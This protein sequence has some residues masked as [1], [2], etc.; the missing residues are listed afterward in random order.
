MPA[1]LSHG[2]RFLHKLTHASASAC[3]VEE[4]IQ[5]LR[6]EWRAVWT[7]MEHVWGGPLPEGMQR[8][9]QAWWLLE[10]AMLQFLDRRG[11]DDTDVARQKCVGYIMYVRDAKMQDGTALFAQGFMTYSVHCL[12]HLGTQYDNWGR[13]TESWNFVNERYAGI[14]TAMVVHWC[15]K[16]SLG[17]YL[18]PRVSMRMAALRS[19]LEAAPMAHVEV[20]GRPVEGQ[21]WADLSSGDL[22]LHTTP[23]SATK[24]CG[25][26][27]DGYSFFS[28]C[29]VVLRAPTGRT[30]RHA[31]KT[32][33]ATYLQDGC[34]LTV[35]SVR[36]PGEFVSKWLVVD[37]LHQLQ[38]ACTGCRCEQDQ[39]GEWCV[40]GVLLETS[41]AGRYLP[42]LQ[43]PQGWVETVALP[44]P[45][46]QRLLAVVVVI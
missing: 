1:A 45:C 43:V 7:D 2:R 39:E 28:I 22:H 38:K 33:F 40:V 32:P 9:G 31:T 15:H 27:Y 26:R 3:S 30:K 42:L 21:C 34:R 24:P 23:F 25:C 12:C 11:V 35:V 16:G 18:C 4:Q 29:G 37:G 19:H 13:L 8:L 6:F 44:L 46:V 41:V 5:F 10:R 14:L 36:L 17:S 20:D